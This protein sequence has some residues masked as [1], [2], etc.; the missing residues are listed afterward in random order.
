MSL[1][2]VLPRVLLVTGTDTGV[3]KTVVTAALAA[4]LGR[5]GSVAVLKPAQT[6]V[7]A[8]EDGDA[9]EV[10]RLAGIASV[11]EGARLEDPLA[12]T[13]AGRRAGIP[14]PSVA[15][16]AATVHDLARSH[17]TVLVEGAGG[18]LVGLD[19]HGDGLAELSASLDLELAFVVVV[20][21]GLGTLNH[22]RLT[23]EALASRGLPCLGLVIGAWPA[24]PGLAERCNLVDLP[25]VTGT[26]VVGRVPDLAG[27]MTPDDFR[28]RAASWFD[29]PI[30]RRG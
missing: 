18:L 6:G 4:C 8:G 7:V 22:S 28:A 10:V 17:D 19:D 29:P 13:T 30:G 2:A 12:P 16:H 3:G 20:R 5:H 15:D 21:A 27:A 11:H 25:T 24:D 26:P 9:A 14:L 1:P 23:V